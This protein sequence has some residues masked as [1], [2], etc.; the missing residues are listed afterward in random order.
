[1]RERFRVSPSGL[2]VA[3]SD[4]T[5]AQCINLNLPKHSIS[6]VLRTD[7]QT[8][9]PGFIGHFDPDKIS[10][11]AAMLSTASFASSLVA[12]P[13]MVLLR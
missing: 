7:F 4:V 3:L 5:A 10:S 6:E 12:R 13:S 2:C 8:L 9:T 1:M 11:I